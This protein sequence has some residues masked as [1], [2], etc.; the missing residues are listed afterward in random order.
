MEPKA[1][2]D[3]ASRASMG[4]KSLASTMMMNSGAIPPGDSTNASYA[5]AINALA[6][7]LSEIHS[8]FSEPTR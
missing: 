7:I 2:V 1:V 3:N 6:E 8:Q 5:E 4:Y